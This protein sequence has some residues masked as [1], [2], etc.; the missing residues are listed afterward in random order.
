MNCSLLWISSSSSSSWSSPSVATVVTCAVEFKLLFDWDNVGLPL[1][2]SSVKRRS[3][4][5]ET[6]PC[7]R[8]F[9]ALLTRR[10]IYR[11]IDG[12]FRDWWLDGSGEGY[13]A[14]WVVNMKRGITLYHGTKR[15][16]IELYHVLAGTKKNHDSVPNRGTEWHDSLGFGPNRWYK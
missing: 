5:L 9:N 7:S 12:L 6:P 4:G 8:T 15:R 2:L 10:N 11:S 16:G 14:V 13:V 1:S 3:A